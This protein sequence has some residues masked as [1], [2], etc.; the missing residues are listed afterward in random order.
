MT[1]RTYLDTHRPDWRDES[2]ADVLAWLLEP[3]TTYDDVSWLDLSM[4]MTAYNL[5]PAI[6]TASQSGATDA[7]KT[8]AQHLLDCITAGQPLHASD[9][10]VRAVISS[11]IPAG[12]ARNA[13]IDMSMR[14]VPRYRAAGLYQ[15]LLGDVRTAR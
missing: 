8:A 13:L 4:W 15:V 5:R 9:I 7:I 1:L 12:A 2:D 6:T 10:R 14:S 11:A 3:V